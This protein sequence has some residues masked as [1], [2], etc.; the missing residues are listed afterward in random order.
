MTRSVCDTFSGAPDSRP[1]APRVPTYA[2]DLT[3]AKDAV[4]WLKP[5]IDIQSA[6]AVVMEFIHRR[7]TAYIVII[8]WMAMYMT[9]G[10]LTPIRRRNKTPPSKKS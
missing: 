10:I 4:Q 8:I 9:T 1:D 5:S 3:F 2:K 6:R 7:R